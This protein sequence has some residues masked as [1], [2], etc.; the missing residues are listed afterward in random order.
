[1][2]TPVE[3]FS[4]S[5]SALARATSLRG[6][7]C[8][9]TRDFSKST[10]SHSSRNLWPWPSGVAGFAEGTSTRVQQRPAST[11]HRGG[12]PSPFCLL[13]D[14]V[15]G[16]V[17]AGVR[18]EYRALGGRGTRERA[19][20]PALPLKKQTQQTPS[21]KQDSILGQMWTLSSMPSIYGND[22]PTGKPGPQKEEPQ[23]SYLDSLLPKRIP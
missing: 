20:G 7:W 14:T 9:S 3:T 1:M 4:L 19:E 13:P 18:V 17:H 22:R 21:W 5:H 6:S 2:L 8:Y 23:G 16:T 11:E 12:S 10:A 15:E